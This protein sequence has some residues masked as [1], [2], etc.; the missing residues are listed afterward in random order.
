M[1]EAARSYQENHRRSSFDDSSP[2]TLIA[3]ELPE[4]FKL[5]NST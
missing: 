4:S 1:I 2:R 3:L 5:K